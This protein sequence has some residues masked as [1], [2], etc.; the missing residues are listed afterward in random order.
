MKMSSKPLI[1]SLNKFPTNALGHGPGSHVGV[2]ARCNLRVKVDCQRED[3][4]LPV[5]DLAEHSDLVV[6]EKQDV[7]ERGGKQ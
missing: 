1:N 6:K 3:C 5:V 2:N 4:V 7:D